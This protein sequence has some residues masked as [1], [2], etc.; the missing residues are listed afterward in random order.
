MWGV[1]SRCVNLNSGL[2]M[3]KDVDFWPSPHHRITASRITAS[4][5][6]MSATWPLNREDQ[7]IATSEYVPQTPRQRGPQESRV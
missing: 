6:D 1:K 2:T 4:P 7:M 3:D 5:P